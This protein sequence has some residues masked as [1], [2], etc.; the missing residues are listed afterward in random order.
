[1]Q[2]VSQFLIEIEIFFSQTDKK[3]IKIYLL[4]I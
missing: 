1:M 2:I 3:K 4:T